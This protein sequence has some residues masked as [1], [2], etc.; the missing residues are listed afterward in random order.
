MKIT[1]LWFEDN[2]I[3]VLTDDEKELWQSLLWYPR[4]KNATTE[5]RNK[6]RITV[7]G[8]HWSEIDEDI[9]FDS[10]LYDDPEPIGIAKVFREH[11]ELNVSAISRRMGMKQSLLAAYISGTKKPSAEREKEILQVIHQIGCELLVV[12]A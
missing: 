2:K 6:Y 4:L 5:Q 12:S 9:S 8:I 7:S 1:K 11:P 3:F 10:F